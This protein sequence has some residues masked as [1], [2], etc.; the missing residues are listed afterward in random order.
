MPM[1][2]FEGKYTV[3]AFKRLVEKPTD[4][5]EIV[6]KTVEAA[7]GKL[8]HLFFAFGDYDVVALVEY[9]D[10]ES[11]AAQSMAVAAGGS[12]SAGRTTVLMSYPEAVRAM[13]KAQA[14]GKA[15]TPVKG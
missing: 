5:T 9:P 2:L 8:H 6:R 4:R 1:Y 11:V 13:K 7:G 12:L 3:D 14:V 10:N 15:Y